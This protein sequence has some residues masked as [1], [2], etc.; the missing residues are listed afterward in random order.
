MIF[1]EFIYIANIIIIYSIIDR[2]TNITTA[3]NVS[4][5]LFVSIFCKD[6]QNETNLNYTCKRL[7][8]VRT[9]IITNISEYPYNIFSC[10]N[11]GAICAGV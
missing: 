7:A 5:Y 2:G 1:I 3:N 4:Y 9:Y 8:V 11:Y 10:K 6:A